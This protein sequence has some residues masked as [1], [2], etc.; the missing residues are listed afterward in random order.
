M[1]DFIGDR[2]CVTHH[3]ACDCREEY[4]RK[5]QAENE[6]LSIERDELAAK[7]CVC[8]G[9]ICED[10]GGIAYCSIAVQLIE[11]RAEIDK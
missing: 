5:L 8:N 10:E 9:A 3:Y 2:E 7:A 4:F 1:S 6:K 11:T